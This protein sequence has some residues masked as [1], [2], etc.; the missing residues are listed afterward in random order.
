M[1]KKKPTYLPNPNPIGRVTANQQFFK[2]GLAFYLYR[3][4]TLCNLMQ[5]LNQTLVFV[6]KM[7]CNSTRNLRFHKSS[8]YIWTQTDKTCSNFYFLYQTPK[9]CHNS[10]TYFN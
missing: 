1:K 4:L 3:I 7:H 2:D 6:R 5:N 8:A 10:D 9:H